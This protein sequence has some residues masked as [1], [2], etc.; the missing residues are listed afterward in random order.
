MSKK[1]TEVAGLAK[2][3]KKP[4]KQQAE[5]APTSYKFAQVRLTAEDA[6]RFRR[7]AEDNGNLTL[8]AAMVEAINA[9]MASWGESPV[10][11]P[12]TELRK[13]RES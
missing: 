7:A 6:K 3:T 8:Q 1:P 10:S 2:A 5:A 13:K 11:D 4:V 9:L 12:G